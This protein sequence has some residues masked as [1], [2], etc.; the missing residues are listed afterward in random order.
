MSLY[1]KENKNRAL[2]TETIERKTQIILADVTV[3]DQSQLDYFIFDDPNE[4]SNVDDNPVSAN[5][6]KY[7]DNNPFIILE[8]SNGIPLIEDCS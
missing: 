6:I 8:S 2:S 3:E 1:Q 7:A 4:N 5:V